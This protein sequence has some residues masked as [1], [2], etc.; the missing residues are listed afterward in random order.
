MMLGSLYLVLVAVLGLAEQL[1]E[2]SHL[3]LGGLPMPPR[4]PS[5]HAAPLCYSSPH[6]LFIAERR[7]QSGAEVG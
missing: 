1:V 6:V 7:K 2:R 4:R 5:Q 3:L